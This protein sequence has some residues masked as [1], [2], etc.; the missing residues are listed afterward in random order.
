M[1]KFVKVLNL[2]TFYDTFLAF[3]DIWVGERKKKYDRTLLGKV[4]E[5]KR[6]DWQH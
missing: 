3:H 5:R 6:S 2:S 4:D 1:F